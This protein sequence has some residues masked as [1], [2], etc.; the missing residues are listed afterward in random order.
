MTYILPIDGNWKI[1]QQNSLLSHYQI[2][3]DIELGG[4][5]LGRVLLGKCKHHSKYVAIKITTKCYAKYSEKEILLY[6]QQNKDKYTRNISYMNEISEIDKQ[7]TSLF[8]EIYNIFE[9]NYYIYIVMDLLYGGELYH[10]LTRVN[11]KLDEKLVALI[12]RQICEAVD[13]LHSIG[14]VHGDLKLENIMFSKQ[15]RL[16]T[17]KLVDFGNSFIIKSRNLISE[18]N[19]TNIKSRSDNQIDSDSTSEFV[20]NKFID[21]WCCGIILY[22]MLTG[23]YPDGLN[24]IDNCKDICFEHYVSNS[25]ELE[26]NSLLVKDLLIRLLS[27]IHCKDNTTMGQILQHSWFSIADEADIYNELVLPH[28]ELIRNKILP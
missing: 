14:V 18:Y 28:S 13:Y 15:N 21:F 27:F 22:I 25:K 2:F 9:D 7:V 6:I 23:V 3:W 11:Q 17:V 16:D 24:T 1:L 4:G 12:F 26:D 8:P 20:Y 5:H 19:N 10:L